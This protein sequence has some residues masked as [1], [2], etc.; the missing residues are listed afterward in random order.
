MFVVG[1]RSLLIMNTT[2]CELITYLASVLLK[3][4]RDPPKNGAYPFTI[5][6]LLLRQKNRSMLLQHVSH[7][8]DC[9]SARWPKCRRRRGISSSLCF[10]STTEKI[11]DNS[12]VSAGV[13][14][15]IYLFSAN[16]GKNSTVSTVHSFF[17]EGGVSPLFT[18]SSQPFAISRQAFGRHTSSQA[19]ISTPR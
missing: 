19:T 12:F 7:K 3:N 6:I 10:P 14:S 17:S 8:T 16:N 2:D 9:R 13:I 15:L 11:T 18:V 5:R 1:A 4:G